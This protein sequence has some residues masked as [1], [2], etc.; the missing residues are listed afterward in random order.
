[1]GK[2]EAANDRDPEPGWKPF[3]SR[4]R[5]G[6]RNR[7]EPPYIPPKPLPPSRLEDIPPDVRCDDD[8]ITYWNGKAFVSWKEWRL[9]TPLTP[10]VDPKYGPR[11]FAKSLTAIC[12]NGTRIF[13]L[14]IGAHWTIWV[15]PRDRKSWVRRPDFEAADQEKCRESAEQWYG[16]PQKPWRPFI[17]KNPPKEILIH[18]R[19]R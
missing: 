6:I 2:R 5:K 7:I 14:G 19:N 18:A 1:M 10:L 4:R 16:V 15:K 3:V 8:T 11:D 17:L 13:C 12:S 9:S